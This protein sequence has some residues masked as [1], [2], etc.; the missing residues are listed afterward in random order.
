MIDEDV[1]IDGSPVAKLH[2]Q[3]RCCWSEE[4]GAFEL[5]SIEL[6]KGVLLAVQE[7]ERSSKKQILF[8]A[9]HYYRSLIDDQQSWPVSR[10]L[11]GFALIVSVAVWEELRCKVLIHSKIIIKTHQLKLAYI[12]YSCHKLIVRRNEKL[13]KIR[14]AY[15]KP[16]TPR[17]EEACKERLD[18]EFWIS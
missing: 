17:D 5:S 4:T 3:Q 6:Q 13:I 10:W 15:K 8:P 2:H 12:I 18:A 14:K 7:S 16:D 11:F 1:A 9:G